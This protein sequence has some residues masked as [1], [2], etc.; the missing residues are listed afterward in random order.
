MFLAHFIQMALHRSFY[1]KKTISMFLE[2]FSEQVEKKL[3]CFFHP[4]MLDSSDRGL[5][6]PLLIFSPSPL[7]KG[8]MRIAI[9]CN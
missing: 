1:Q 2:W 5:N 9:I 6:H 7:Y 8:L 4:M 3:W